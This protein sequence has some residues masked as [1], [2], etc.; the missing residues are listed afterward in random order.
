MGTLT[1]AASKELERMVADV[2]PDGQVGA[3]VTIVDA[4]G[5]R[6][7]VAVRHREAFTA[8]L[9]LHQPW[10]RVKPTLS[11]KVKATW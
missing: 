3:A 2:I 10:A 4:S 1:A 5:T 6:V 8:S 11:L 9:E 7:G